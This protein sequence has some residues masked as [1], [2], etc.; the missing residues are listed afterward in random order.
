MANYQ[1]LPPLDEIERDA[2]TDKMSYG[3][4][5]LHSEANPPLRPGRGDGVG[6]MPGLKII[7]DVDPSDIHQGYVGD[8]WLLSGSACHARF[9]APG[10]C[11]ARGASRRGLRAPSLCPSSL[12]LVAVDCVTG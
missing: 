6:D 2:H 10:S 5:L 11:T 8:C 3:G 1:A 7:G 4:Q 12:F 9:P